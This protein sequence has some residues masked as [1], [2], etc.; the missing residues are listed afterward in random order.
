[1]K[2]KIIFTLLIINYL[3]GCYSSKVITGDLVKDFNLSTSPNPFTIPSFDKDYYDECI[4]IINS[5]DLNKISSIDFLKFRCSYI[6]T[7]LGRDDMK[8]EDELGASFEN[9]NWEKV[10]ELSDSLLKINFVRIRAHILKSFALDQLGEN[11]EAN[12]LVGNGLL[13]SILESGNGAST[14][15]PFYV[16]NVWEEYDLSLIHISEPTRPY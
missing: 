6:K 9:K 13:N 1:M 10:I 15:T 2:L 16:I 14:D 5:N 8:L 7:E 4:K 11:Y 3:V 12:V